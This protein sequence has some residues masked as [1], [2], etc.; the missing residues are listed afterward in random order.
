MRIILDSTPKWTRKCQSYVAFCPLSVCTYAL[1]A[2]ESERDLAAV[3]WCRK[4]Y[5]GILYFCWPVEYR[6]DLPQPLR[7]SGGAEGGTALFFR[8]FTISK[9]N[10]SAF[11]VFHAYGKI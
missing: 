4:N 11:K 6:K 8:V 5:T 1:S 7:E 2:R 10:G 9:Q 3:R